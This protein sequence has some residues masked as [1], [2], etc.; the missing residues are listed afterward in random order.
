[1]YSVREDDW[2]NVLEVGLVEAVLVQDAHLFENCRLAT[3]AGASKF[4]IDFYLKSARDYL[5]AIAS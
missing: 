5:K 3:L 1:M 2:L 4:R